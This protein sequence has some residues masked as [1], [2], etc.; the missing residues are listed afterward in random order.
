MPLK[1]PTGYLFIHCRRTPGL[2]RTGTRKNKIPMTSL[3]IKKDNEGRGG[4][5]WKQ[6]EFVGIQK[7]YRQ[8]KNTG[9][10]PCEKKNNFL[11]FVI[12]RCNSKQN[13]YDI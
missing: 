11:K 10:K 13:S 8:I 3:T 5:V 4:I 7:T 12:F 9:P 1:I 6:T 2:R